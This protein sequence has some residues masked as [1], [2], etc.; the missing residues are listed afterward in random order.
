MTVFMGIY[1]KGRA[2]GLEYWHRR[3]NLNFYK[4]T[5]PL[6]HVFRGWLT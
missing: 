6:N 4:V 2:R 1:A 3:V 5:A